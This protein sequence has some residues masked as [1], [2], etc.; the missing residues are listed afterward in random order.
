MISYY[1]VVGVAVDA[2]VDEIQRAYH[3]K[4][5]LLHPDRHATAA[6]PVQREAESAMKM[7]N[8]AWN[9]LKDPD[10]RQ[11][12]DIENALVDHDGLVVED[13]PSTS[14]RTAGPDECDLCGSGPAAPVVLRQETGKI[15]WRTRRRLDG[16]FCRDCG[17]ALFRSTQNRTLMTGWWGAISFF[18]NIGS[19]LRNTAAWWNLRSL[20]AP[21]RDPTVVSYLRTPLDPGSPLYRRA[22]VWFTAIVVVVS[23]SVIAGAAAQPNVYPPASPATTQGGAG[24]NTWNPADLAGMR[25]AAVQAGVDLQRADC[26]VGYLA[27]RYS[28]SDFNRDPDSAVRLAAYYCR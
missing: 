17:L 18:A 3:R 28:P 15:V 5:Q 21:G 11:R 25:A 1:D 20:P 13:R 24:S 7:L 2:D 14:G 23:G 9:T 6:E 27:S 26:L 12:Y 19:V 16:T 4:A 22:G 8:E 10:S